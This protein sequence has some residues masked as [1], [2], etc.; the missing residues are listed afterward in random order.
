MAMRASG[1]FSA[2]N[3]Y[4]A[5]TRQAQGDAPASRLHDGTSSGRRVS[6]FSSANATIRSRE[7][8]QRSSP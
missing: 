2:Q 7:G 5:G 6:A 1:G 3:V 8:T 4:D